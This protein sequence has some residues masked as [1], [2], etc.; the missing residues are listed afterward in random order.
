MCLFV[1]TSGKFILQ[2]SHEIY[3]V[4][5]QVRY[6]FSLVG[7]FICMQPWR[8]N[9]MTFLLHTICRG[10]GGG[11]VYKGTSS[12]EFDIGAYQSDVKRLPQNGAHFVHNVRVECT[13][14][15]VI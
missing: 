15:F 13:T 6:A 10:A 4:N 9:F 8:R 7:L 5:L 14:P 1:N 2:N 11:G 12:G 3:E